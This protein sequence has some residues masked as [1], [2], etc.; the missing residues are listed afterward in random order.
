MFCLWN[1]LVCRLINGELAFLRQTVIY[2]PKVNGMMFDGVKF[3]SNNDLCHD[4]GV[5]R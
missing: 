1:S 5:A 3:Q 2:S 4:R